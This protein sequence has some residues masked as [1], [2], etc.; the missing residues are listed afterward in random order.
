[1][2]RKA[3]RTNEIEV[4]YDPDL[5]V[6]AAECVRG[7]PQVFDP[8]ARPWIRPERASPAD[9]ERV[10]AACPTGALRTK[11]LPGATPAPGAAPTPAAGTGSGVV[12]ATVLADGPVVLEGRVVVRD[13]AGRV[14][15]EAE[16]VALCRCGGSAAKPFCD[17]AH[18]RIGFRSP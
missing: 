14:L 6:H 4:S 1:M 16:K 18:A 15:R 5:C 9:V 2:A 13:A 11:R 3:Y 12:V 8:D 17:G 7:L 10:V